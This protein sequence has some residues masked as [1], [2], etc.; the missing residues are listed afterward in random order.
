MAV[1]T[2]SP[3][4]KHNL[5][6]QTGIN[7]LTDPRISIAYIR[8]ATASNHRPLDELNADPKT[9][10]KARAEGTRLDIDPGNP[11]GGNPSN[12]SAKQVLT[13]MWGEVMNGLGWLN[14]QHFKSGVRSNVRTADV[15]QMC[16]VAD[17]LPSFLFLR[18][19]QPYAHLNQLPP[20]VAVIRQASI[21][22][23]WVAF[24]ID[25][26]FSAPKDNLTSEWIYQYGLENG[27]FENDVKKQ[28]CPATRPMAIKGSDA[29]LFRKGA[30]PEK[31]M[32]NTLIPDYDQLASFTEHV[33][34]YEDLRF[35]L[36]VRLVEQGYLRAG[37]LS[38]PDVT[39]GQSYHALL[40]DFLT[41]VT[42]VQQKVNNALGYKSFEEVT[43]TVSEIEASFGFLTPDTQRQQLIS[44]IAE[45]DPA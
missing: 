33:L 37:V 42:P 7:I 18:K 45:T 2:L 24:N 32:F 19:N 16:D 44:T 12:K 17:R 8:S 35:G 38:L 28:G 5:G 20:E 23:R 25:D 26:D 14:A 1:N 4:Q 3:E 31:S 39:V 9:I 22:I 11:R 21:G 29:L 6:S 36:T 43:P 41:T 30:E 34:K 40:Q 27:L 13:T 10:E 15:I